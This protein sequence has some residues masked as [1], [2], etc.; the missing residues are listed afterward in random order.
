MS[1]EYKKCLS[2][3]LKS[4]CSQLKDIFIKERVNLLHFMNDIF[5]KV[6][7]R[8]LS[9]F[10]YNPNVHSSYFENK[11]LVF[12]LLLLLDQ[13]SLAQAFSFTELL[14]MN[15]TV[16]FEYNRKIFLDE[17]CDTPVFEVPHHAPSEEITSYFSGCTEG[18][19]QDNKQFLPGP[20]CGRIRCTFAK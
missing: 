12:F 3:E 15:N 14:F 4:A 1:A 5:S 17:N 8:T 13:S 16:I 2:T 18:I 20:P 19:F 7:C 9:Y 11:K 10:S 6:V